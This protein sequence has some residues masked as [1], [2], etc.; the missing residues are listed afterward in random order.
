MGE[1][2][3]WNYALQPMTKEAF[4]GVVTADQPDAPPYFTYDAVLNSQERPTLDEALAREM[5]PLDLDTVLAIQAEGAQVL[6][7]R[8]PDEF[9]AA[10]LAGS[11]NVGLGG[12]YATW[13]G[14]VLDHAHPIVII[15]AP[16]REHESAIRLGRIGFDHVAGYL[17]N[18][19]R[20]LD[21]R[22]DL[23]VSTERL[24]ALA[25]AERLS[26]SQAPLA[27]PLVIDVRTP[28]EREQKHIEGSLS[29]PLNRLEDHLPS[30][31]KDRPLLVYCA[32]GYRSS[33]AASL[34]QRSGFHSVAEIAGGFSAWEAANLPVVAPAEA[35]H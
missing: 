6:D 32:G 11:I 26:S 13:A 17:E 1:Q 3:R 28:R 12:Q 21:S 14:T 4:I 25:A 22:P 30:L 27:P 5:N 8:D 15:A 23:I 10:H 18:G 2:R 33:L 20:A 9:A 31:P 19:L 35:S 7:T 34:L 29:V 16:G 24:S